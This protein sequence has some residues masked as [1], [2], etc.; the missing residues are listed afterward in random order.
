MIE[1]DYYRLLRTADDSLFSSAA[2]SEWMGLVDPMT[3]VLRVKPEIDSLIRDDQPLFA[4]DWTPDQQRAAGV[5]IHE[6]VHWWQLSGSTLGLLH[7]SCINV[8]S[9]ILTSLLAD[10]VGHF[11]PRKSVF[12]AFR[13]AMARNAHQEMSLLYNVVGRWMDLEFWSALADQRSAAYRV[14][15]KPFFKSSGESLLR[16]AFY[17]LHQLLSLGGD[18]LHRAQWFNDWLDRAEELANEGA[19]DFSG[20]GIL[21]GLSVGGRE[22]LEGQARMIEAQFLHHVSLGRY[23]FRALEGMGYFDGTYGHALREFTRI[24]GISWPTGSLD[25]AAGLFL[26]ACDLAINPP[27]PYPFEMSDI[28]GMVRHCHP[29][30]RFLEVCRTIARSRSEWLGRFSY[31]YETHCEFTAA[32]EPSPYHHS[33]A[34]TAAACVDFWTRLSDLHYVIGDDIDAA[35]QLPSTPLKF[36]LRKHVFLMREKQRVPHL[37]CWYGALFTEVMTQELGF[38]RH[39]PP[40]LS[41]GE[42]GQIFGSPALDEGKSQDP[43]DILYNFLI[44]QGMNDIIRQWVA[45]PGPF[46]FNYQWIDPRQS[47]EFWRA[48]LGEY[49]EK[50]YDVPLDAI[51]ILPDIK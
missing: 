49:F 48:A 42:T 44:T 4:F 11:E 30:V 10:W 8:Q 29:G 17:S 39:G 2:G 27:V 33:M 36:L 32:L 6:I 7:A 21:A 25:P 23:D 31:S 5:L 26:L 38:M 19:E 41:V 24:T 13:D 45:Q 34:E 50:M 15:D 28:R 16:A 51:R 14:A 22:I 18:R 20:P 47:E 37:L 9:N 46:R 12:L 1:T 3:F 40:L 43:G 35:L